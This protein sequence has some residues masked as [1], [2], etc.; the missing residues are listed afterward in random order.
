MLQTDDQKVYEK[1][2]DIPERIMGFTLLAMVVSRSLLNPKTDKWPAKIIFMDQMGNFIELPMF[3]YK[4]AGDK[5]DTMS[6]CDAFVSQ[7]EPFATYLLKN[8]SSSAVDPR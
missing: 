3:H 7:F 8:M 5:K 4:F 6:I 1:I 2:T